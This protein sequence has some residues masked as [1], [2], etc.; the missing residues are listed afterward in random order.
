[1]MS[2]EMHVQ[3]KKILIEHEGYKTRPYL[4][5]ENNLTIGIGRN[6]SERD[7]S[8]DEIDLFFDNDVSYFYSKFIDT[9][10]W[11]L[12]LNI[13]RQIALID[14]SFMGFKT[15]QTFIH[16]IEALEKN[17]FD[18]AANEV[19]KSRYATQV[20]K[21]AQDIANI[22]KTGELPWASNGPKN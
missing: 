10:P 22:L 11:F 8:G 18:E 20:G 16:L 15:F 17:D 4:D 14:M 6:L 21:R 12:K 3:L 5:L 1:M 19:L 2:P 7:M 13:P 9:Y